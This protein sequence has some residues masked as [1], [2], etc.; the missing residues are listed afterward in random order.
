MIETLRTADPQFVTALALLCLLSASM[1]GGLLRFVFVALMV[2]RMTRAAFSFVALA[3]FA[4][5]SSK[6]LL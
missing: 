2:A 6:L 3:S 5:F 1:M 4:G